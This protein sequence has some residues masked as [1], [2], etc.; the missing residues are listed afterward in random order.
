MNKHSLLQLLRIPHL[1][2]TPLKIFLSWVKSHP[3]KFVIYEIGKDK[4]WGVSM[5][6]RYSLGRHGWTLW[7]FICSTKVRYV[8]QVVLVWNTSGLYCLSHTQPRVS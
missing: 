1:W 6:S 3:V 4:E 2:N 7:D 5:K 8:I